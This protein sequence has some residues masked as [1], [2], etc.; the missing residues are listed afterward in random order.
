ML[1]WFTDTSVFAPHDLLFMHGKH[2]S[3][4]KFLL[5]FIWLIIQYECKHKKKFRELSLLTFCFTIFAID[6]CLDRQVEQHPDRVAFIWEKDEPSA[7]ETV[8]YK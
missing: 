3:E 5:Q 2:Q 6:N 4:C 8:T 1:A 7:H